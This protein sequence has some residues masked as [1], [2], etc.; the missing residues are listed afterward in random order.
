MIVVVLARAALTSRAPQAGHAPPPAV[1][2]RPAPPRRP[3]R[4]RTPARAGHV[5]RRRTRGHRCAGRCPT[6]CGQAPSSGWTCA[7]SA[8]TTCARSSP[9][10]PRR[11][12]SSTSPAATRCS[13]ARW[14]GRSPTACGGP[15]SPPP[16]C[17]TSS[18]PG[19]SGC[20]TPVARSWAAAVVG[21]DFALG[22]VAA[23]L[24]VPA[25]DCL[26]AVDEAVAWGLI[27]PLGP[28][29]RFCH[30]LTRDAVAATL[31]TAER[32]ALHRRVA[33]A[34]EARYADDLADGRRG[35]RASGS[36]PT[37]WGPRSPRRSGR[38]GRPSWS[39]SRP[40]GSTGA[41]S[42]A[43]DLLLGLRPRAGVIASSGS[44]SCSITTSCCS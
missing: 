25:V 34:I 8:L 21:R 37:C 32:A 27:E 36:S 5:P 40:S 14:R 33:V 31:T 11:R 24:D 7:A 22:L 30:A 28:D 12:A 39:G 17:A 3:A 1:A 6:C 44:I 2:A 35:S 10:L 18:R 16:R 4:R 41:S 38:T 43:R 20:R 13:S 23:V 42:S 29:Y 19:W 9:S 15:T 26:P